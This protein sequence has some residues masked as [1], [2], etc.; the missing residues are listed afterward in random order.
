MTINE[1][2]KALECCIEKSMSCQDCP[3]KDEGISCITT[4]MTSAL[5]IIREKEND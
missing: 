1:T 5:A 3:F 2:K 4:V